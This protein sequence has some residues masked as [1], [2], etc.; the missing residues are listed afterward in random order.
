[1]SH[2]LKLKVTAE[3]V[4][5]EEQAGFLRRSHCDSAQGYLFGRPM[6]A[7]PLGALLDNGSG[8]PLWSGPRGSR[9]SL[10][11]VDDDPDTL[12]TLQSVLQVDGY[13]I[14]T[15]TSAQEAFDL[16]ANTRIAVIVSDQRMSG[17]SGIEFLR[18]AKT[19]YP[20]TLRIV[21]S[22]DTDPATVTAAINEGAVYKFLTK[23]CTNADL[24]EDVRQ[25]FH[26]HEHEALRRD[27]QER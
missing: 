8:P 19:M 14:H 9:R 16:L 13:D 3:G 5:T 7:A 25:A 15:A 11:L 20:D 1:M 21:L 23:P 12:D 17:M 4:E 10:L 26:R 27:P 2:H 24:R 18:R 6:D 22:E